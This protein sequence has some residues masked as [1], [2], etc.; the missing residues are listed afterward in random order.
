MKKDGRVL[1]ILAI[2][3][4]LCFYA[5]L[6]AKADSITDWPLLWEDEEVVDTGVTDWERASGSLL[7]HAPQQAP[8]NGADR[9]IDPRTEV[10]W[11]VATS[12]GHFA[13]LGRGGSTVSSGQYGL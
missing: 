3:A 4:F 13:R 9:T 6:R 2:A 1:Q 11:R 12:D 7:V 10:L 5:T 8:W